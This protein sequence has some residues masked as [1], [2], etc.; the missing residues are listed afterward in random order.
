MDLFGRFLYMLGLVALGFGARSLGVLTEARNDRLS[1]LAFYV[2]LP[3]LIFTSTYDERLGAILSVELAVATVATIGVALVLSWTANHDGSDEVR[4]VALVQSYHGNLGFFGLPVVATTL[5]G[6]AVATATVILGIAALVQVPLTVS[7][8]VRIND[9][10]A[11]LAGELRSLVTNPVLL[12]LA[13]ALVFAALG[14]SLPGA[15]DAGLERLSAFALPTALLAVGGSLD[16]VTRDVSLTHTG[17][18]VGIK[19]VA[20][21]LVA[22]TVF[23]ALSVDAL[24]RQ[25]GVVMFGAP[26]AVATYVYAAE[27]GG[28]EQFASVNVFA[29]TVASILSLFVLLQLVT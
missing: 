14:L 7:V 23:S 29:T 19:T 21:P 1:Q 28:D 15:V 17:R 4:S 8:L 2:L 3:A 11:S 9:A 25:A 22:W 16:A 18:V 24:T 12:T 6:D 26:T 13:A 5:G 27:L 10:S 20:M